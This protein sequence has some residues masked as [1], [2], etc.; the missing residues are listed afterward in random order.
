VTGKAL[1]DQNGYNLTFGYLEPNPMNEL[2]GSL[3]SVLAGMTYD[4]CGGCI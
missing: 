3:Q 1:G 2:S 4:D